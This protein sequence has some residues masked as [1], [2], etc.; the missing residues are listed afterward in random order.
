MVS[1]SL[2]RALQANL[3]A[4]L[5]YERIDTSNLGYSGTR[6]VVSGVD[7]QPERDA[8]VHHDPT[9]HRRLSL[10]PAHTAG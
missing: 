9:G 5:F 10:G 7:R 1:V 4:N 6:S 2:G 3:S 8:V